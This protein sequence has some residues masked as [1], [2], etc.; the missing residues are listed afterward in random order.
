V[1]V[2]RSPQVRD[3]TETGA[4]VVFA[5]PLPVGTAISLKIDEKDQ[6]GRVTEVIES[7]DAAAAGMRVR[8]ESASDRRAPTPA[9][10]VAGPADAAPV[11]P[12]A[13]AEPARAPAPSAREPAPAAVAAATPAGQPEA[14]VPVATDASSGSHGVADSQAHASGPN[15][16]NPPSASHHDGE[17]GR[18]RRRRK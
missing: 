1:V 6:H 2:G 12:A 5:E 7:A 17:G 18:R 16:S 4:F 11:P 14:P 3:R 10:R 15:V 8:F 13:G 9:P